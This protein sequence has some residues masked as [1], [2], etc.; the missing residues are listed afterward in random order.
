MEKMKNS[1]KRVAAVLA[2][3]T[4]ILPFLVGGVSRAVVCFC[5]VG[6]GGRPTPN[7]LLKETGCGR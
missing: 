1:A 2:A 7:K 4:V 6:G 5:A 3:A